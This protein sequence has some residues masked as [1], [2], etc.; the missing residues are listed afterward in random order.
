[1]QTWWPSSRPKVLSGCW[2]RRLRNATSPSSLRSSTPVSGCPRPEQLLRAW[3]SLDLL[4]LL[5]PSLTQ[6]P[7]QCRP[8]VRGWELFPETVETAALWWWWRRCSTS[9]SLR[10]AL[11]GNLQVSHRVST[12]FF[13]GHDVDSGDGESSRCSTLWT[14]NRQ[15]GDAGNVPVQLSCWTPSSSC[16]WSSGLDEEG[17]QTEDSRRPLSEAELEEDREFCRGGEWGHLSGTED[18]VGWAPP[19]SSP[20]PL[21]NSPEEVHSRGSE[22]WGGSES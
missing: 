9:S 17:T 2:W 10:V 16:L 11:L 1:M 4:V 21:W 12:V 6:G 19:R 13:S 3:T 8:R 22:S 15:A 7:S 20:N 5:V 18:S 14:G